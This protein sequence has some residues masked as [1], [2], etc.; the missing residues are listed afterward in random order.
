MRSLDAFNSACSQQERR[1]R[2]EKTATA[3]AGGGEPT[4]LCRELGM[5]R[6][7]APVN[8]YRPGRSSAPAARARQSSRRGRRSY[9]AF[10]AGWACAAAKP[11]SFH[12]GP[13][14]AAPPPREHGKARAGGGA[15]TRLC[16]GLGMRRCKAPVNPY[17]PGR[18]G[19]LAARSTA[20]LAPGAALLQG[21]CGG[22]GMRRCKA[23]VNPYRAFAWKCTVATSDHGLRP[24]SS[25]RSS[26]LRVPGASQMA[27]KARANAGSA[28]SRLSRPST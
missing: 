13:V 23:P 14:G 5:R 18:S 24:S 11:R 16:R 20:K 6:C 8:P 12:A 26:G 3:R 27:K 25:R 1:P 28:I 22:L 7:K 9:K 15:P 4:R 17:R 21:V 2:R 19:A 10:A